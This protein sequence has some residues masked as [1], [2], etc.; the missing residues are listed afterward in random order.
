MGD[1]KETSSMSEQTR[2]MHPKTNDGPVPIRVL[3]A[4]DHE[5]IRFGLRTLLDASADVEVVGQALDGLEAVR[6]AH[7]IV[8][9]VVLMDLRMPH[10]DGLE[11]TR[12]IVAE[13]PAVRVL[14]LTSYSRQSLVDAAFAAGACGYVRKD[15]APAVLLDLIRAARRG[16]TGIRSSPAALSG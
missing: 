7:E 11:A 16:D 9:D 14:V 10:V 3:L 4:D 8:P 1:T 15:V 2:T 12:A 13:N 5:V 6:L